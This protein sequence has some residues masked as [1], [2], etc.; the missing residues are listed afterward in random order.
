[1]PAVFCLLTSLLPI[2]V[3][4]HM[5]SLILGF[6]GLRRIARSEGRKC[7]RGKAIA[8]MVISGLALLAVLAGIGLLIG[9]A[10]A[11]RR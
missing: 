1:M 2:P 8:G 11:Q 7:G 6:V 9:I 3:L 10:A 4:A 5:Y